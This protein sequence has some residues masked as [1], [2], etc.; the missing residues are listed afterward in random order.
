MALTLHPSPLSAPI[1]ISIRSSRRITAASCPAI[2]FKSCTSCSRRAGANAAASAV[3]PPPPVLPAKARESTCGLRVSCLPPPVVVCRSR[4]NGLLLPDG[5]GMTAASLASSG[6]WITCEAWG[7]RWC[8]PLACACHLGRQR[9]S[10]EKR[11]SRR[12]QQRLVV[13]ELVVEAAEP[14]RGERR[15]RR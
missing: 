12:W 9:R 13:V 2:S 10:T 7:H 5:T 6:S 14:Y 4:S 3:V 1:A 8:R 15:Q 11:R